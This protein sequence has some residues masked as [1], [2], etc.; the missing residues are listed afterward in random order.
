MKTPKYIEWKSENKSPRFQ[1]LK[2][3]GDSSQ[4]LVTNTDEISIQER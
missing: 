2:I 1:K 4:V 3:V